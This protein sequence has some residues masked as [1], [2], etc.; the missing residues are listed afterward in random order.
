MDIHAVIGKLPRPKGGFTLP[1]HRYTGPYNPLDKQLDENDQP[2]PGQEPYNAVDAISMRHDIC[3]RDNADK[4]GGKHQC[5][6]K[7]LKELDEMKPNGLREK[8]DRRLVRS[9]IGTKRR[10]GLGVSRWSDELAEELHKPVRKKFKRRRV[11]VK[12]VDAIWAAD[13]VDMRAFS[14]FNQGY[15]YILMIIDVFSKF[16]WAIPLKNKSAE[17]VTKAFAD[18]WKKQKPPEK[19]WV[20][21]ATEFFNRSMKAL[22]EK[23]NVQ[24]YTTE[25]EEKSSVVERWN[26]TIKRIMWKYFTANN[27]NAYSNVLNDIIHKYNNTYHRSIKCTPTEAREPSNHKRVYEALFGE[28]YKAA[29]AVKQRP[30]KF[31]IG[32]K[33]RIYRKKGTFEKGFTPNWTEEVFT[34]S[35]VKSTRPVTYS[36]IDARGED[37]KGS[38]YENEL[39]K[40]KQEIYRIEKVIGKRTKNG[41]QEVRVKWKGYSNAFNQWIPLSDIEE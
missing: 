24:I 30:P 16:G 14:K 10:L 17:E 38:F 3:Y 20:D 12:G 29:A 2:I 41:K 34:I 5:D 18:L 32:D 6:D 26:R 36:L 40:T 1:K 39:Q 33:V 7:M 37:I 22:R 4:K 27:T 15:K 31:E 25:N 8:L 21:K 11:Y 23:Y 28:D 13:L 9:L 19:L 35:N